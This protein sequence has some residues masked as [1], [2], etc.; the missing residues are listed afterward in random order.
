MSKK[1]RV[2]FEDDEKWEI[3]LRFIA[4]HRAKYYQKRA[5]AKGEEDFNLEEEID[6]IMNDS[7][8]GIDWASNN[9]DWDDVMGVAEKVED[10]NPNDHS[11]QWCNAEKEIVEVK[12]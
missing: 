6:F 12:E 10:A 3:P 5:E 4:E 11:N 7:Y 8:E 1:L 2:T 9:M